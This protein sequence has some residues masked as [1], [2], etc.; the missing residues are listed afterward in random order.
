MSDIYGIFAEALQSC[1]SNMTLYLHTS[2]SRHLRFI[3]GHAE[4]ICGHDVRVDENAPRLIWDNTHQTVVIPVHDTVEYSKRKHE[5]MSMRDTVL[6]SI[7]EAASFIVAPSTSERRLHAAEILS[8]VAR[9]LISA[10]RQE[11][12]RPGVSKTLARIEQ[13]EKELADLKKELA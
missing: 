2:A 3:A 11:Q 13:M 7:S 4:Y 10:E 6:S 9:K 8:E 5:K 12:A 1:P